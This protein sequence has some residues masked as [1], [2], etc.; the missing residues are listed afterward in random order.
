[1]ISEHEH[2]QKCIC[3]DGLPE[4]AISQLREELEES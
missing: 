1:M 3:G 2:F 4:G